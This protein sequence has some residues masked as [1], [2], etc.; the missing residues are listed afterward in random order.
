[1]L[2]SVFSR[3]TIKTIA[4][5]K[6]ENFNNTN[7]ISINAGISPRDYEIIDNKTPFEQDFMEN[8][9]ILI[10]NFDDVFPNKYTKD[11]NETAIYTIF[12]IE[13]AKKIKEFALQTFYDSKNLA[14]HCTAGI[15][16][17]G[18]VGQ[19]LND[20]FNKL[21]ENNENDWNWFYHSGCERCID[22]NP[23]VAKLLKKELGMTFEEENE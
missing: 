19:V 18:A 21:I 23:W 16:R 4:S 15:S 9:S 22:P 3:S 20:Y 10:L 7:I 13:D 12:T 8:H 1:M 17:S 2:I 14:I 6:P 5:N 11:L